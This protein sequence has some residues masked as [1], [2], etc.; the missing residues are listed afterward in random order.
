MSSP[1]GLQMPSS[2][3]SVDLNNALWS[4]RQVCLLLW[5]ASKAFSYMPGARNLSLTKL[6]NKRTCFPY[7]GLPALFSCLQYFLLRLSWKFTNSHR[8]TRKGKA[9]QYIAMWGRWNKKNK[10]KELLYVISYA[11]VRLLNWWS[12]KNYAHILSL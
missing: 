10:L 8:E 9:L 12:C 2:S 3:I 4:A 6:T 1:A 5:G 11:S 7:P